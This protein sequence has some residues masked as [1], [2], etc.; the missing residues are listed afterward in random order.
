MTVN[1]NAPNNERLLTPDE[2]A[3]L[4]PSRRK[5]RKTSAQTIRRWMFEGLKGKFL[6]YTRV[7]SIPCSTLSAL[8]EF[9]NELTR[10]DENRR[11]HHVDELANNNKPTPAQRANERLNHFNN[12]AE[13]LG[14]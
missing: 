2:L 3:E 13:K 7:G 6:R 4:V 10:D 12:R 9:F 14:L 8:D 1:Q 5:G 11:F